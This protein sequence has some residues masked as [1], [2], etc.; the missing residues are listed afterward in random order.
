MEKSKK[1]WNLNK[2]EIFRLLKNF[3]NENLRFNFK[4]DG[5]ISFNSNTEY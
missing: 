5:E 2:E 1:E 3:D 4:N